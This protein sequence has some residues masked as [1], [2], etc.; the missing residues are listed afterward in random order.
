MKANISLMY[1]N[2]TIRTCQVKHKP[3]FRKIFHKPDVYYSSYFT[4]IAA[5]NMV[6]HQHLAML[7]PEI[8]C[9]EDSPNGGKGT[10]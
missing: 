10:D 2:Y 1:H 8:L 4:G 5:I 3:S 6:P 7:Q 9:P